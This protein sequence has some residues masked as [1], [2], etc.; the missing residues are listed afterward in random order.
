LL[1]IQL[2]PVV[3]NVCVYCFSLPFSCLFSLF[4]DAGSKS[5]DIAWGFLSPSDF[6]RIAIKAEVGPPTSWFSPFEFQAL[7]DFFQGKALSFSFFASEISA[8]FFCIHVFL[9]QSLQV[10][11]IVPSLGFCHSRSWSFVFLH[12]KTRGNP[13]AGR[14][15]PLAGAGFCDDF[16]YLPFPFFSSCHLEDA[17]FCTFFFV[18]LGYDDEGLFALVDRGFFVFHSFLTLPFMD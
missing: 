7:I 14:V 2:V 10:P 12:S 3:A 16:F 1:A 8:G 5:F 11:P 18:F 9:Q 17:I 4:F 6:C 15:S 13:L